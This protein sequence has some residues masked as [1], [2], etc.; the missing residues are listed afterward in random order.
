MMFQFWF[1]W[2][3]RLK[4][5][6]FLLLIF[7]YVTKFRCWFLYR[8][9][10]H[11]YL[12]LPY[13]VIT[14]F[15]TYKQIKSSQLR[16]VFI[17]K[18]VTFFLHSLWGRVKIAHRYKV[19]LFVGHFCEKNYFYPL[20]SQKLIKIYQ[21]GTKMAKKCNICCNLIVSVSNMP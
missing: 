10:E 4:Y 5:V 3:H 18:S 16:E 9:A 2:V 6:D 21:K 11:Y 19:F 7:I 14:H 12:Y 17:K 20:K 8:C 13:Y 1:I 15:Y